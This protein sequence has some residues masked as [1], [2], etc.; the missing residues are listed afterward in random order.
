MYLMAKNAEMKKSIKRQESRWSVRE[1]GKPLFFFFFF[2][3]KV[4]RLGNA[5]L[6]R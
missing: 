6:R 3:N 1:E 4:V 5:F 2:F